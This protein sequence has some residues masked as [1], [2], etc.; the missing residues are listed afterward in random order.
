MDAPQSRDEVQ[1]VVD[2]LRIAVNDPHLDIQWEPKAVLI[3]RGSYD[4]AGK[5]I[6]P[7]YNGRWEIRRYHDQYG[8]AGWRDWR[9]ICFITEPE[10]HKGMK[11]MYADGA[12]AP[13][14]E[15]VVAFM[16]QCDNANVDRIQD[17]RRK[18]DMLDAELEKDKTNADTDEDTQLLDEIFFDST[19]SGGSGQYKGR[20]T[21]FAEAHEKPPE[22][23]QP[24][25]LTE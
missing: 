21:D 25:I 18:L 19:Y 2:R 20:G 23:P 12:Y 14:G 8:T 13:V 17:A 10:E 3:H 15:W 24:L 6:A 1:A 16:Q 7:I 11:M 4:A 5:L 9:R 22:T